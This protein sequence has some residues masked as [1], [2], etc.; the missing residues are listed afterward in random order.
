MN[1]KI[2][3]PVTKL[4]TTNGRPDFETLFNSGYR[5]PTEAEWEMA[6]RAGTDTRFWT[7]DEPIAPEQAGWHGKIHR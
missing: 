6:C 4:R 3:Q 1:G 7:G 5:F 2:S